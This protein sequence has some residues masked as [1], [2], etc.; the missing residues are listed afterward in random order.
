[1]L[2][3]CAALTCVILLLVRIR[4]SGSD[5]KDEPESAEPT[6]QPASASLPGSFLLLAG[7][8]VFLFSMINSSGFAFPAADIASMIAGIILARK[9]YNEKVAVWG[10]P[11]QT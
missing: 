3:I 5:E 7:F 9:L 4:P 6:A 8:L 1:M 2:L 10:E 11:E